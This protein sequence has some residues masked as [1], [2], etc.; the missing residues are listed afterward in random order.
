MRVGNPTQ[1]REKEYQGGGRMGKAERYKLEEE[2]KTEIE[3][4]K[5]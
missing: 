3:D 4:G 2:E 5:M 1:S